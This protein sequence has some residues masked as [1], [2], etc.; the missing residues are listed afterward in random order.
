M[1][2]VHPR[3]SIDHVCMMRQSPAELIE[4]CRELGARYIVLSS[5]HL[6]A[7]GGAEQAR[8]ALAGSSI[9]LASINGA[10]AVYPNLAADSGQ[11]AQTLLKLIEIGS[12][13][14]AKSLYF[15]TGGRAGLDW[16]AAAIR[17]GEL[18]APCL[19]AARAQGMQLMIENAASLYA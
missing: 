13:L 9:A 7:D 5:P 4:N 6:L 8:Q 14:G 3:V 15:L 18:V 12:S 17:F 1:L 2:D 19:R 10:F 16:D 11:A